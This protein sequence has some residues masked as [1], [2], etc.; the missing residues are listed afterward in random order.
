MVKEKLSFI[1]KWRINLGRWCVDG[2]PAFSFSDS[3]YQIRSCAKYALDY[4]L[5]RHW[6]PGLLIKSSR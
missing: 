2:H 6:N 3:F 4:H 5:L 1:L